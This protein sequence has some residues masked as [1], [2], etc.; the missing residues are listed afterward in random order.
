MPVTARIAR[1]GPCLRPTPPLGRRWGWRVEKE[2]GAEMTS[3]GQV[4]LSGT[5][6]PQD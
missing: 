6:V 5:N 4:G 1:L 2:D 3:D